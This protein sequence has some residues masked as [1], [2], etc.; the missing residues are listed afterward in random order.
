MDFDLNKE[1]YGG[2]IGPNDGGAGLPGDINTPEIINV[3]PVGFGGSYKQTETAVDLGLKPSAYYKFKKGDKVINYAKSYPEYNFL[4]YGASV[5][6]NNQNKYPGAFTDKVT[7]VES[8]FISLYELN[9][10]RDFSAHTYDPE[11]DTGIKTRIYPFITKDSS[12]NAFGSVTTTEWNQ[13]AYGTTLTGTYPMSASITR[14]RFLENHGTTSTTGSHVLALKN[15]LNHYRTMSEHYAFSSSYGDKAL[16][17]CNLISIP[18]IFFGKQIKKGSLKL[19]YYLSGAI[20]GTLEDKYKNGTLVQTA[21]SEYAQDQGSASIG[22][23]VLYNEGFIFLTGA[24]HLAPDNYDVGYATENPQWVNFGAGCNDGLTYSDLTPSASF[25]VIFKGTTV[26]PTLTMFAYAKKG[27]LNFS[28]NP[29][30]IDKVSRPSMAYTYSS[31][32][33]LEPDGMEFKNTIS[34]SFSTHSASF[35]RQTFISTVGIYD[36]NKKL[37]AVANM[38]RPVRKKETDGYTFKLKLDI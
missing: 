31:S 4:I 34:S 25:E 27:D 14:E 6:L 2:A 8:G 24:W 21:G 22:G 35:E 15:T 26:T 19:N 11:A 7:E 38:A 32:S 3:G 28:T 37:I 36:S 30:F 13:F 12:L 23:V 33:F 18:S 29:T 9:V 20:I 5:Y 16:Q 1:K 17:R 10:D